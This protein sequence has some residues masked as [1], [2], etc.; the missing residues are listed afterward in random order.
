MA[1]KK[2]RGAFSSFSFSGFRVSFSDA[3]SRFPAFPR[4]PISAQGS[5]S[6][7][8]SKQS[9][10]NTRPSASARS[11]RAR[12]GSGGERTRDAKKG[13]PTTKRCANAHSC[14]SRHAAKARTESFVTS[15]PSL[16]SSSVSEKTSHEHSLLAASSAAN[17]SFLV[18]FFVETFFF[19]AVETSRGGSSR[20]AR[21][22]A[23]V[24]TPSAPASAPA[25]CSETHASRSAQNLTTATELSPRPRREPSRAERAP[26]TQKNTAPPLFTST[27]FAQLLSTQ[28]VEAS[29][30]AH[31]ARSSERTTLESSD[32][33]RGCVTSAATQAS[34][35]DFSRAP[36]LEASAEPRVRLA[37]DPARLCGGVCGAR[38]VPRDASRDGASPEIASAWDGRR[39][40]AASRSMAATSWTLGSRH[41]LTSSAT[42]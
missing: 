34:R 39:C 16:T 22:H 19:S 18:S 29:S 15:V 26:N 13:A 38:V 20:R 11:P 7:F 27:A 5:L 37:N 30:S 1:H 4:Q 17:H 6:A 14:F 31:G 42:P 25:K 28:I 24:A 12:R 2:N 10:T 3:R 33:S 40:G 21:R 9:S 36:R 35:R 32:Q 8:P 41:R 23:G